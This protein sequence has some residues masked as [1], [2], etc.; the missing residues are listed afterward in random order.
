MLTKTSFYKLSSLS[1]A[2]ALLSIYKAG[3]GHPGGS[4]S[5]TEVILFL[6]KEKL[7]LNKKNINQIHRN[8]FILSKGHCAP[9]LYSVGLQ[10]GFLKLND[11]IK[12]RKINSITQGHTDLRTIPW[13]GA[14]TGS[15]GQGLSFAVGIA[16]GLKKKKIDKHVYVMIGDG[17]LQEGQVWEALMFASHYKLGNLTIIL[18]YNKLQSDDFNR[19]IMNLEPLKEKIKSFNFMFSEING[20]SFDQIK[21]TFRKI[22]NFNNKP[23]FVLS[24]TIK[25][26]GVSFMENS[27]LWHG[28]VKISKKQI[29]KSFSELGIK[30]IL[31]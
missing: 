8:Y 2:Y 24:H 14:S 1:R 29:R 10:M 31:I 19:N 11:L 7:K 6:F 27:K 15:L 3:S 22:K 18:D 9:A 30:K 17:E 16:L 28:S 25:G 5:C 20:H 13:I 21:N 23:H 12:L 4:L 26:K